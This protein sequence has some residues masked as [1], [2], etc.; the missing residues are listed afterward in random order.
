MFQLQI[1]KPKTAGQEFPNVNFMDALQS[2]RQIARIQMQ[3]TIPTRNMKI[4]NNSHPRW[5]IIKPKP[6]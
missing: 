3:D 1:T 5:E 6:Y 4:S 2:Q